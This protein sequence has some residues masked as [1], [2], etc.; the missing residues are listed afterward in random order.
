MSARDIDTL[1][2]DFDAGSVTVRICGP[3]LKIVG[4]SDLAALQAE[5]LEALGQLRAATEDQ[6]ADARAFC[7]TQEAQSVVD[8]LEHLDER[9]GLAAS[10]QLAAA[11]ITDW[12]GG[13][14]GDVARVREHQGRDAVHKAYALAWSVSKLFRGTPAQQVQAFLSLESGRALVA[15]YGVVE[16]ALPFLGEAEEDGVSVIR[17]L[18]TSYGESEIRAMRRF[19]GADAPERVEPVLSELLV[20]LDAAIGR[21]T[22]HVDRVLATAGRVSEH[23]PGVA[24]FAADAAAKGMDLL[25]AYHWLGA[26][27]VAEAALY[28]AQNP[29]PPPLPTAPAG[30]ANPFAAAEAGADPFASPEEPPAEP[31]VDASPPPP[32]VDADPFAAPPSEIA[33]ARAAKSSAS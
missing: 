17:R 12:R 26:R 7:L 24:D 33:S 32:P 15:L 10:L 20:S 9:D 14:L 23:L 19:A 3:L 1:L 6:V 16:V 2:D 30:D 29:T 5:S 11:T 25:P 18:T 13:K 28:R 31:E 8:L 27:L 22:V 4:G 21:A